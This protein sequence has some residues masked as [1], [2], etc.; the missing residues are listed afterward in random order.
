MDND[1]KMVI[2]WIQSDGEQNQIFY[3]YFNGLNWD[4]P[5]SLTDNISPDGQAAITPQV[6]TNSDGKILISW[7]QFDGTKNQ[8]FYSYFNGVSWDHPSSLEDN[9]SPDGQDAI[10]P[11]VNMNSDGKMLI[12]WQQSDGAKWQIFNSYFDGAN[13][14]HPSS[15]NDNISPDGQNAYF[16]QVAMNN[17]GKIL[18]SWQQYDGANFQIFYSYFNG[19]S[20]DHPSS[21]NDNISPDGQVALTPQVAMNNDGKMLISWQQSDGAH[22]Q[23]FYS[24]FDGVSWDHPSSLSDNISP[25]GQFAFSA[26]VA[27]NNSGEIVITWEQSDGASVQIFYSY[28]NG[29][30]WDHPS[31]LND[32]ISPDG[33]T[34]KSPVVAMN[35]NGEIVITWEQSN[36]VKNQTFY[37][38]FNGINWKHPS[39]INDYELPN[40]AS[41]CSGPIPLMTTNIK[42]IMMTCIYQG[43]NRIYE[44]D[45]SSQFKAGNATDYLSLENESVLSLRGKIVSD[46]KGVL[47]YQSTI[48][49]PTISPIKYILW[50]L[51]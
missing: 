51:N 17:D 13:W 9:I 26:Q 37:S 32:N 11:R 33:Q 4:H 47:T 27:M 1:G 41:E 10:F 30:S 48:N 46:T 24:Y 3:S 22:F 6:A 15:L 40:G 28:F 12:S 39:S 7:Q 49:T 20:W 21:L 19:A 31:N 23:I 5:S 16:P 18:I 38:Y 42:K 43:R 50:G 44:L 35:N 36:G 8:I 25:D 34:A 14:V 29:F 2:T 45:S